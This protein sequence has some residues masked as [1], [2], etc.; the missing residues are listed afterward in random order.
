MNNIEYRVRTGDTL[1]MIARRHNVTVEVLSR[2]NNI[3]DVN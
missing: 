1:S 3:S 2:L